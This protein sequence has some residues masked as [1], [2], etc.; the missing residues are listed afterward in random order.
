[1]PLVEN[2]EKWSEMILIPAGKFTM[3]TTEDEFIPEETP[4]HEVHLDDYYIDKYEVTNAQYWE[5]LQYIKNYRRPQQVLSRRTKRKRPYTRHT[6]HWLGLSI[7]RFPRLSCKPCRLVR[8]LCLCRMGRANVYPLKQNGR[9]LPEEQTGAG[10]H[11]AM[12]GMLKRM[13]RRT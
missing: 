2:R 7:F 6:S 3:G 5:F 8:C 4:L 13:Q 1:M 11:G 9:K 10:F 12:C